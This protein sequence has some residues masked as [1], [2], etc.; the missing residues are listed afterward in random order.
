V[1]AAIGA[2]RGGKNG[3]NGHDAN[4][5]EQLAASVRT[6]VARG[7]LGAAVTA[8]QALSDRGRA[9]TT[10]LD[11]ARRDSLLAAIDGLLATLSPP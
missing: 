6:A 4:E 7:D 11:G 3:L 9:M 8:A 10:D 2:A 5:L 1:D